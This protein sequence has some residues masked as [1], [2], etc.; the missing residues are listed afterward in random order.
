M[1]VQQVMGWN[2]FFEQHY[3]NYKE[4]GLLPARVVTKHSHSYQLYFEGQFLM[5]KVAGKFRYHA[6]LK[7][8]FPVVGDWV[9]FRRIENSNEAIIHEVMPR[10]NCFVR[11][12]PISGGRRMSNGIIE[13]GTTE[14]Q[15]IAANIDTSFIVSGLDQNFDIRRIERFITLVY[16]SGSQPVVI[17]NKTDLCDDVSDFVNRVRNIAINI[18]ILAI[19]VE[20]NIN[21]DALRPYLQPGKT[22][23]FLGSSG[24]GKSTIT[25]ALLGEAKQKKQ[26][27][28]TATG[29]GRHTT[30]SA[31]LM[32]HPT[33]YTIIDTP[34]LREVQ[35]W[36]EEKVLEQSFN[37]IRE[38]ANGC[39]YQDCRHDKEPGC[40]VKQAFQN[41]RISGERLESYKKQIAE[42]Q[43]L[44]E[45]KKQFE[46]YISRKMKH[47]RHK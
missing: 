23:V 42:L 25:N 31:E 34:G 15:V 14:E 20:K 40:A 16:N 36:G 35:L 12:L 45:K 24:V 27:I 26:T 28:S 21:M 10:K 5:A 1:N 22:V 19:S 4:K 17:L 44:D 9:V 47:K 37:D 7:K 39:R 30:T 29:K 46:R 33:G 2:T 8:H 43:R 11:K 6:Y 18:P 41:E 32:I 3:Q 13:G 38:I